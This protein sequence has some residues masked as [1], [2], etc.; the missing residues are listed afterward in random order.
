[1]SQS[2]HY[3]FTR[4]G[5]LEKFIDINKEFIDINDI[6]HSLSHQCRFNGHTPSFYSVAEHSILTAKA[7]AL[8]YPSTPP[9]VLLGALLHDGNECYL[10]DIVR[11]VK[12]HLNLHSGFSCGDIERKITHMVWD[13]F[14]LKLTPYET[15]QIKSMDDFLL[16]VEGSLFFSD[17]TVEKKEIDLCIDYW[18]KEFLFR[19]SSK[20]KHEFNCEFA[21]LRNL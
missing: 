5:S 3:F 10:G 11:P 2:R 21:R 14:N 19:D 15:D 13:S 1:M 8:T 4:W 16:E 18:Q 6:S 17:W 9:R 12:D 20:A 7:L